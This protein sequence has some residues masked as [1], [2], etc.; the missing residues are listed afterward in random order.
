MTVQFGN[1][2]PIV[3]VTQPKETSL[4]TKVKNTLPSHNHRDPIII[5]DWTEIEPD[6]SRE[7]GSLIDIYA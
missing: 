3:A 7:K 4:Q 2:W 5:D 6:A 1:H